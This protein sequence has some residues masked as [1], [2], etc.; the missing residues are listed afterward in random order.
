[1]NCTLITPSTLRSMSATNFHIYSCDITQ[2]HMCDI[3]PSGN[4]IDREISYPPLT[5][6]KVKYTLGLHT[7]YAWNSFT[8]RGICIVAEIR[9]TPINGVGFRVSCTFYQAYYTRKLWWFGRS[10]G[11]SSTYLVQYNLY[12]MLRVS[13]FNQLIGLS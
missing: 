1:M 10:Y 3:F 8:N 12:S 11:I 4:W 5:I 7:E 9:F 2:F 6:G 13:M